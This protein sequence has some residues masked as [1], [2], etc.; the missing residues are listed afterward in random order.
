M[1]LRDFLSVIGALVLALSFTACS[2]TDDSVEEYPNWQSKNDAFF[3]A[4]YNAAKQAIAAGST[5]WKIFKAYT[6][7]Y[8][9]TGNPTDY[10]VVKV[11]EEGTGSG[12]PLYTDTVRVHYKG[13]LL[14]STSYTDSGDSEL[15]KVFDT[16]WNATQFNPQT[17]VPTKFGV[18]GL[19]DGFS[20]ALQ[21]MH[22]G[23]RW[24]V[25]VPYQL[26]YNTTES[27]SVPAYSV[28][29]YDMMLAAYYRPGTVVPAWGA[30][31]GLVWEEQE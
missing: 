19:I 6:K 12:C 26:G 1:R 27:S 8:S 21:H 11:I 23:D 17:S 30:N 5:S 20:T 7:N 29:V 28:L 31:N 15:G 2:E 13:W 25:Y 22:I 24:K 18:A 16:S 10:I 14:S 9:T 3:T 4:K